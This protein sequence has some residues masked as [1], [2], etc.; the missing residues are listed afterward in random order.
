MALTRLAVPLILKPR[1]AWLGRCAVGVIAA[2]SALAGSIQQPGETTGLA[3]GPPLPRGVYL[4]NFLNYGVRQSKPRLSTTVDIPILA[5]ST[6]WTIAGGRVLLGFSTPAVNVGVHGGSGFVDWYYPE[7]IYA[8][9]WH[10][11]PQLSASFFGGIYFPVKNELTDALIGDRGTNRFGGAVTYANDGW[12]FSAYT[13]YGIPYGS[14]ASVPGGDHQWFN[15]DLTAM[16][17]L[18][19]WQLG[20]VAY[21]STDTTSPYN[22]YKKQSQLAAGPLVGYD[23]GLL[24]FQTKVTTEFYEANYG[25]RDSRFWTN[26]IVPLRF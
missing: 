20:I 26:L 21:G 8:L 4:I 7:I 23:F 22:G 11:T 16:K 6:P 13:Q 5:W 17:S 2:Q 14:D 24:I 15:L 12:T 10:I 1:I 3:F 18:G 19:K 25:G 9:G